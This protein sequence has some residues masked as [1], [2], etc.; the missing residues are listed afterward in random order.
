M[1]QKKSSKYS[2]YLLDFF[3]LEDINKLLVGTCKYS[4]ICLQNIKKI[5]QLRVTVI[6]LVFCSGASGFYFRFEV[7][8]SCCVD[9]PRDGWLR[10]RNQAERTGQWL[11]KW[12]ICAIMTWCLST[13]NSPRSSHCVEPASVGH[14]CSSFVWC[15][16]RWKWYCCPTLKVEIY[17]CPAH[18]VEQISNMTF[19]YNFSI[20]DILLLKN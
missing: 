7:D 11:S 1:K 19:I 4:D 16:P 20:K 3:F 14:L 8:T 5:I 2:S 18:R 15:M 12:I 10:L 9:L 13:R 6:S 17:V